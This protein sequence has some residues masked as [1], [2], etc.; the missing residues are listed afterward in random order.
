MTWTG[1]EMRAFLAATM[2]DRFAPLW[3][4]AFATGMRRGELLGLRWSD[5]DLVASRL[6]VRQTRLIVDSTVETGMPKSRAGGRTIAL[7][8]VTVAALRA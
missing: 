8:V 1:E 4:L 3:R 7:D 6:T 5:V 2:D